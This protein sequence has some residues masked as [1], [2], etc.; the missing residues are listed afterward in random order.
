MQRVDQ[1][2]LS[3]DKEDTLMLEDVEDKL[4]AAV[5]DSVAKQLAWAVT[6]L[7]C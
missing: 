1:K 4:K 3:G 7:G 6:T 2:S 5:E